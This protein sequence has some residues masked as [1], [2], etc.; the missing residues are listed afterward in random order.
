MIPESS[1]I[2]FSPIRKESAN[3]SFSRARSFAADKDDEAG[4][5]AF[6]FWELR[7]KTDCDWV[8]DAL[9][10]FGYLRF[11]GRLNPSFEY[12]L[13]LCDGENFLDAEGFKEPYSLRR[14]MVEVL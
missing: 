1:W 4:I 14:S 8:R 11:S 13:F 9:L 10:F 7:L 6:D 5:L 2:C 12:C 3:G